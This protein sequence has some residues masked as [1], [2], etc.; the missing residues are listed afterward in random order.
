MSQKLQNYFCQNF[1]KFPPT[2]KSFGTKMAN[3]INLCEV[4][5]FSTSPNLCHHTTVLNADV[6]KCYI[7]LHLLVCSKLSNDLISTQ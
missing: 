5:S 4:Y 6:P 2:A 7:T 3:K 1:V